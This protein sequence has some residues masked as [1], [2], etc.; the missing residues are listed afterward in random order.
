MLA[1][2]SVTYL[3]LGN[4]LLPEMTRLLGDYERVTEYYDMQLTEL[5]LPAQYVEMKLRER[6]K[7]K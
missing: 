7:R 5:Y 6:G 1:Q 3:L 2:R 4:V